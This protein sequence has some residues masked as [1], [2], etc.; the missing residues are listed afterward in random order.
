VKAA[1]GEILD[2]HPGGY[3][4]NTSLRKKKDSKETWAFAKGDNPGD[5]WLFIV[6]RQGMLQDVA[7]DAAGM[8]GG[9][10]ANDSRVITTM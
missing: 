7:I 3:W 2:D 9:L 4:H 5:Y 1:G 6:E 10:S 8:A